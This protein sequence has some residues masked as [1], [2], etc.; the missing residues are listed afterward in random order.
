MNTS[1]QTLRLS[2]LEADVF[3]HRD[4]IE[5]VCLCLTTLFTTRKYSVPLDRD[6]GLEMD[7]LDEPSP[8]AMALIRSAIYSAADKYEPRAEIISVAFEVISDAEDDKVVPVISW[9]LKEEYL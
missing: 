2:K 1:I 6:F 4:V 9:K 3:S 8:R 7:A 5:D